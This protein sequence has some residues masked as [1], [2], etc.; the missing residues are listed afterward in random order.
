MRPSPLSRCWV[1]GPGPNGL[2]IGYTNVAKDDA[3]AA[4]RRMLAAMR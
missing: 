3:A 1:N 4:A 2:L